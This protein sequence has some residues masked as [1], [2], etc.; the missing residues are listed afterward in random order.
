MNHRNI[1]NQRTRVTKVIQKYFCLNIK[2]TLKEVPTPHE[3]T[4][5]NKDLLLNLS[6]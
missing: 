1:M 4:I 2:M 3:Y 6:A 5:Y